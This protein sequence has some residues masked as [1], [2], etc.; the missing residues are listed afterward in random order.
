V[1]GVCGAASVNSAAQIAVNLK[2]IGLSGHAAAVAAAPVM[3]CPSRQVPGSPYAGAEV[4]DGIRAFFSH[5]QRNRTKGTFTKG[6]FRNGAPIEAFIS[7]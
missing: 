2:K 1:Y 7:R 5:T 6:T 4:T 3:C